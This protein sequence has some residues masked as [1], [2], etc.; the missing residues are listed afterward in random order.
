MS[1][2][3]SYLQVR[4]EGV[5]VGK[6]YQCRTNISK[7]CFDIPSKIIQSN[8]FRNIWISKANK[9]FTFCVENL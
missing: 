8:I 6:N 9:I 4:D 3:V 1:T 5:Y 2:Y 7:Y